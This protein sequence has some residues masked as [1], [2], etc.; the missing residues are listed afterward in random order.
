MTIQNPVKLSNLLF[1]F[2]SELAVLFMH[3]YILTFWERIS[4]AIH[5]THRTYL[6][7]VEFLLAAYVYFAFCPCGRF[8]ALMPEMTVTTSISVN[9][10][11]VNQYPHVAVW[12][13]A[14]LITTV[15]MANV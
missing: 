3:F 2:C 5:G 7:W 4:D 6:A 9:V 11:V 8:V 10:T 13:W 12:T 14:I 15:P 1:W